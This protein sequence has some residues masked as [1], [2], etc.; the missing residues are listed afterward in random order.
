MAVLKLLIVDDHDFFRR[1]IL[2][3]LDA[4]GTIEVVGS[5]LSGEQAVSLCH[6]LCPDVVLLDL[7]MSPLSGLATLAQMITQ[8]CPPA[9]LVLTVRDDRESIVQA[10]GLGARGYLRKDVLT[11][12]LLLNAIFTVASGGVFIDA[13]TFGTLKAVFS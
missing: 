8:D 2:L 6:D 3:P 7:N 10:F 1:S 5:A 11:D 4:A 13:T 12:E 9:I